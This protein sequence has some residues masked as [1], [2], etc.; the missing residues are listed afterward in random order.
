MEHPPA[1]VRRK[2]PAACDVCRR[3][4]LR[5]DGQSPSCSNCTLYNVECIMSKRETSPGHA[6]VGSVASRVVPVERRVCWTERALFVL[7]G[8]GIDVYTS[9]STPFASEFCRGRGRQ[10]FIAGIIQRVFTVTLGCLAYREQCF[11]RRYAFRYGF[12]T[13]RLGWYKNSGRY[14][15]YFYIDPILPV[16]SKTSVD[17]VC[18]TFR[19]PYVVDYADQVPD[20]FIVGWAHGSF[21]FMPGSVLSYCHSCG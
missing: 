4:R 15:D 20:L 2:A 10:P 19:L 21:T 9:D 14:V 16:P 1:T 12:S 5:C 17:I 13:H 7:L 8:F 11:R 18:Q 3:R 6:K